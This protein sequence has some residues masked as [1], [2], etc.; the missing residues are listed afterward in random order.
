M[1]EKKRGTHETDLP[2]A[3]ITGQIQAKRAE[4]VQTFFKKGAV[5]TEEL[6]HENERLQQRLMDVEGENAKLRTQLASDTAMRDLLKKINQLETEKDELLSSYHA[7]EAKAGRFTNRFAEIEAELEN[8]ANLYVASYQL[9]S[10]LRLDVVVRHLKELL[11]QL[12]GARSVVFYVRDAAGRSLVPIAS[13]GAGKPADLSLVDDARRASTHDDTDA[14]LG[15]HQIERAYLTGIPSIAAGDVTTFDPKLP[16]AC[17]PLRFDT[18]VVGVI[19]VYGLFEQKREFVPV[20][21]E[22]FKLLGAHA[23]TALV[24]AQ[25]YANAGSKVPSLESLR[26]GG[27]G[28]T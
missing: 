27:R 20:D 16:I 7:Q 26:D 25:L 15:L 22:L 18:E 5:F 23:G 24:G 4:F 8:F 21:H 11:V 17:V 14:A 2:S 9:H 13:E 28:A 19:V 1:I 3:D 6:V 10:T 12:V